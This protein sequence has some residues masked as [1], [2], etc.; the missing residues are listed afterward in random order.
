MKSTKEPSK[1]FRTRVVAILSDIKIHDSDDIDVNG[2]A[3]RILA[4]CKEMLVPNISKNGSDDSMSE[5]DEGWNSC[6]Q[7]LL[8][9]LGEK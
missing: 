1:D 7:H 2:G 6:R 9:Q 5:G 4:L 8:K 3:D